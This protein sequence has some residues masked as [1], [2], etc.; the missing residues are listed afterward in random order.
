M[1]QLPFRGGGITKEAVMDKETVKTAIK[2]KRVKKNV[3]IAEV[4]KALGKNPTFVAA[5]LNGKW[6]EYKTF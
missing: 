5:A 2:D 3:T 6:L 1:R 4:A